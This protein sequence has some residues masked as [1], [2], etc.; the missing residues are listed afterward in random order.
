MICFCFI[1]G[2]RRRRHWL[3]QKKKNATKPACFACERQE[4]ADRVLVRVR[5]E[6]Q[7]RTGY[8]VRRAGVVG[9]VMTSYVQ[10]YEQL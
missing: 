6:R 10:R 1:A 5:G 3:D 4:G 8:H 7:A 2:F 9:S